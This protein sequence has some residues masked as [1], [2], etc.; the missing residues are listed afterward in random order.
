VTRDEQVHAL[1]ETLLSG[2]E[3]GF[4][5]CPSGE[6]ELKASKFKFHSF[7]S[8]PG[9]GLEGSLLRGYFGFRCQ[10]GMTA[11]YTRSFH[12][13]VGRNGYFD[14]NRA[15]EIELF[16]QV[17]DDWLHKMFDLAFFLDGSV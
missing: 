17:G 2:E 7:D 9:A 6:K 11:Q 13:A 4:R 16:C 15:G 1:K 14:A 10:H 3:G 8:F 5:W 12:S